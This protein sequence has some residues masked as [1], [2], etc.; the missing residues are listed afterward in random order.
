MGNVLFGNF[1]HVASK[2]WRKEGTMMPMNA[3]TTTE[4]NESKRRGTRMN[5]KEPEEE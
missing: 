3:A 2:W 5:Q 4:N 1:S